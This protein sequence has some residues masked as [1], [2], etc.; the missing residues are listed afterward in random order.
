M[1]VNHSAIV[2]FFSKEGANLQRFLTRKLGG[3]D[4][5]ADVVQDTYVRL[6][7]RVDELNLRNSKSF[8]FTVALNLAI[9]SIRRRRRERRAMDL[10][11]GSGT[12]F[13]GEDCD[14]VCPN[15]LPDMRAEDEIRLE[16]VLGSLQGLSNKC[17]SAF[18]LHKF[19]DLSYAEVA[20]TLG[21]TVSMV[22]KYL[23][24]AL[25]CVREEQCGREAI[26]AA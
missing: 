23:S 2:G 16:S 20:Q 10:L 9:D 17:R 3:A 25:R 5:A 19:M 14:I 4:D 1:T 15:R 26:R 12:V 18:I 6:L 11:A 21:I 8:I 22:E 24:R 7:S 13:D